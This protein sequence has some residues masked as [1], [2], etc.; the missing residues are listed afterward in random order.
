MD[1]PGPEGVLQRGTPRQRCRASLELASGT[2]PARTLRW[3]A[4]GEPN[5]VRL[6]TGRRRPGSH[7][8]VIS[9]THRG[10]D[11]SFAAADEAELA[12][13]QSSLF[14]AMSKRREF[15]GIAG[16]E[17]V[18]R[19]QES[20]AFLISRPVPEV[21]LGRRGRGWWN[22]SGRCRS[23]GCQVP[24]RLGRSSGRCSPPSSSSRPES[25]LIRLHRMRSLHLHPVPIPMLRPFRRV[26][27]NCSPL[28]GASHRSV[29][30]FAPAGRR[31]PRSNLHESIL[32]ACKLSLE[33]LSVHKWQAK[34]SKDPK[35]L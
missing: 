19:L 1:R 18:D 33:T 34:V 15:M 29:A 4:F 24:L 16:P 9:R 35:F 6:G 10:S 12:D 20:T 21:E 30:D 14:H 2:S 26:P 5:P 25:P 31:F 32:K 3:R 28:D 22:D 17:P 13:I 8:P 27:S 11:S 23:S 7:V